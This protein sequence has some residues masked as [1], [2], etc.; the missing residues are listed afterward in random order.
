MSRKIT[1]TKYTHIQRLVAF[2]Y[3]RFF[4]WFGDDD[5]NNDSNDGRRC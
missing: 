4:F 1:H 2:D 5:D 3:G